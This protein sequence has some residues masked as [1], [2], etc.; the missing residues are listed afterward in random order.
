[1]RQCRQ[2]AAQARC[3]GAGGS[4]GSVGGSRGSV[5]GCGATGD[6]SAAVMENM[7]GIL[8]Y[9]EAFFL[10]TGIYG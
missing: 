3:G 8:Q 6:I 7:R 9:F 4:R 10:G 2:R 5:S 1:M